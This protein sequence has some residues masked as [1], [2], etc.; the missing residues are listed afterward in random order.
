MSH[1]AT[2]KT[3]SSSRA[4]EPQHTGLRIQRFFTDEETSPYDAVDWERRDTSIS[5]FNG[6]K[7]FEQ[8][9]VEVPESWS[10]M[11]T[12]VVVQ[13]YFRGALGSESRETSIR[14]LISRVVDTITR[15]GREQQYFATEEDAAA[16]SDDLA[17]MLVTQRAAFNSPV[18]FNVGVED[19]PQCSACFINEVDD[20]MESILE[21]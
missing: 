11:A 8:T 18:W 14:Q 16:F 7:V 1:T 20:T 17:Y 21:L 12:N 9:N 4:H 5:D 3:A 10:Q 13:K 15:W 19:E 6:N 2:T